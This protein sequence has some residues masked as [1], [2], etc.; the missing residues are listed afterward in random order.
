VGMPDENGS[1]TFLFGY[2]PIRKFDYIGS[3]PFLLAYEFS[4]L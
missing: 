3:A 2:K 4:A 1:G